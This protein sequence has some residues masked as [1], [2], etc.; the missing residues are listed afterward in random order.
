[1]V[2]DDRKYRAA[3]RGA[4]GKT[5]LSQQDQQALAWANSNPNDPRAKQIKEHLGVK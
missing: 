4:T 1:M 2:E 5:A 3:Q